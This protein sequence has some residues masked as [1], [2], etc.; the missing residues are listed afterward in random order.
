MDILSIYNDGAT[1]SFAWTKG[2]SLPNIFKLL[3]QLYKHDY[4]GFSPKKSI[5]DSDIEK[6][7]Q[8]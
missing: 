4:K 3:K 7:R 1:L 5:T 8:M 6:V 2:K